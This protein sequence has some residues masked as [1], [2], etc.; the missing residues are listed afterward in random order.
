MKSLLKYIFITVFVF[1]QTSCNSW[2]DI[3]PPNGLIREEFWKEKEDV[4]AV[5][6]AAYESFSEIDEKLWLNGELRADMLLGGTSQS[7]DEK[8]IM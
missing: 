7:S 8:K 4:E 5:L 2:L 1:L 3:L 6:M